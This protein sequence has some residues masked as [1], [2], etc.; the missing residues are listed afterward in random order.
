MAIINLTSESGFNLDGY[1]SSLA[2]VGL[3]R[4]ASDE[5]IAEAAERELKSLDANEPDHG[6]EL[7]ELERFFSQWCGR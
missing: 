2:D 4:G 6:V 3:A 7:W 5:Q 1:F